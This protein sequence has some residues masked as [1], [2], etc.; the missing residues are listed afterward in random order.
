EK[1]THCQDDSLR[2]RAERHH[3]A[4]KSENAMPTDP[5]D[6]QR[7]LHELEVHQIELE[8]QNIELQQ[9]R[10]EAEEA[11]EIYRDLYDIAPVG[12]FTLSPEGNILW[13]PS[14][15]AGTPGPVGESAYHPPIRRS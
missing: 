7:L 14:S 9:A 10:N 3:A 15:M 5:M 6:A 13:E 12:Y 2:Q 4:G 11:R 8:M 1:H